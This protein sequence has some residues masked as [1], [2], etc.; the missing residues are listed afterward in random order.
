MGRQV[1]LNGTRTHIACNLVSS[2]IQNLCLICVTDIN[3]WQVT[4][5]H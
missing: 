4:S 5:I 2:F 3:P 1:R